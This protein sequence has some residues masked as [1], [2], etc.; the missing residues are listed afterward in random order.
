MS[1]AERLILYPLFFGLLLIGAMFYLGW[2]MAMAVAGF[3]DW[4][5]TDA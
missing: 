5:R 2:C 1:N 3:L 4:V